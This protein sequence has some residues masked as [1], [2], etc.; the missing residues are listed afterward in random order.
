MWFVTVLGPVAPTRK[1]ED[2]LEAA[3]SLLAYRITDQV[4][5]LAG[6]PDDDDP[7]RDQWRQELTEALRHW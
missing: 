6:Q 7:G 1:T 2:W 4:L 5:A 3:T